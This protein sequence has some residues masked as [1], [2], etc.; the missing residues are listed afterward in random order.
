MKFLTGDKTKM[1]TRIGLLLAAAF[2][3][4]LAVPVA[5]AQSM[6][7]SLNGSVQDAQGAVVVGAGVTVKNAA[8]GETRT[9]TTNKEGYFSIPSLPAGAYQLTVIAKG[10]E[11]FHETGIALT[12]GDDRSINVQLKVGAVTETVEAVGNITELTPSSSGEKAFTM[13]ASEVQDLSLVSRDATELVNI[14]PGAVMTPNGAV[15]S[16]AF[17]GQAMGMN[18]TTGPLANENV[19]GM[20]VDVTTDGGHTFDP[21]AAGNAV[22]VTAN[23]DM[24][25]EIKLQTSNFTA[26]NAKGPVVVNTVTKN[27]GSQFHGDVHFIARN[28]VLNAIDSYEKEQGQKSTPNEHYYYPGAT[29]GGP[30]I[31]PKLHI[32]RNRDKL[33]FFDGFEAYRQIQDGGD[34]AA[35]VPT[36]AML[37]GDFSAV[38]G[39]GNNP[40]GGSALTATPAQSNFACSITGTCS[41]AGATGSLWGAPWLAFDPTKSVSGTRLQG[42]QISAAGVLNSSCLD[43]NGVALMSA[44][45]PKPTTPNGAYDSHGFNYVQ[46][47]TEPENMTQELARVDWDY[48]DKTKLY[49]TFNRSHQNATFPMGYWVETAAENSVPV[50]SPIIGD[51]TTDFVM[52]NFMHVISPSMTT[53]SR[54]SYTYENYPGNPQDPAKLQRADIPNFTLKGIWDQKTAP[55]LVTWGSGF[56]N[57]G[58]VGHAYPLLCYKKIPSFGED[59]TKVIHTHTLKAGV[60]YEWVDNVQ[61]N[62]NTW[63]EFPYATWYPA[64]S[65]NQYADT[66]MGVGHDGYSENAIPPTPPNTKATMLS[67]Y[68]Q[69]DWKINR[70]ISIQYGMRFDH[71]GKP[72]STPY[73]VAVWD[74]NGILSSADVYNNDPSAIAQN[75]GISWH[76]ANKKIPWSGQ[77]STTLFYS[78]RI[79]GAFDVFGNGRTVLRGG[80][81]QYRDFAIWSFGSANST[82]EG[83][84]AWTCGI[85]DVNCPSWEDVDTHSQGPPVF[86]QPLPAGQLPTPTGSGVPLTISGV[87]DARDKK[88]PYTN[89]YSVSIDQR[90]PFKLQTE[91]SYVGSGTHDTQTSMDVN[92]IPLGSMP[93]QLPQSPYCVSAVTNGDWCAYHFRPYQNYESITD[94]ETYGKSRFDSLQVSVQRNTG[95]LTLLINYT[96]SKALGDGLLGGDSTSGYPDG[97]VSEYYGVLPIDRPQ[98]LSTAYVIHLPKT[99]GGNVLARGLVNGWQISG[100]T[101]IESGANLTSGTGGWNFDWSPQSNPA[102]TNG[103]DQYSS[104][105][106]L[107]TPDVT[108]MPLLTCN[109]KKGNAKGYYVN[110]SCFSVPPGNGVNGT[111]KMPYIPGPKYWKSDLTMVKNFKIGDHQNAQFRAAAFDFLNHALLSFAPGD[112]NLEANNLKY[113][114]ADGTEINLNPDFGKANWHEGH[115][116][117]E[118][119]VKY[120]F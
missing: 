49:V 6:F 88:N 111:T 83:S 108:L 76:S 28:H 56:P 91:V 66:L 104:Q 48:S 79:G 69:D 45:L 11:R 107:G 15:N 64:V 57:L 113:N 78:P 89:T 33:F 21:G 3:L 20:G 60:Y 71:Y 59:L 25:S 52:V 101:Q 117:M 92:A 118:F 47:I 53:E 120:S 4:A 100:I 18:T 95:F 105:W 51:D 86:G 115:R 102:A 62:W 81:G 14:M 68:G 72:W 16:Q 109:P 40:A 10:F 27:G 42:C 58:D 54:F 96:Y 26:D 77:K 65:G 19:N 93:M 90:L 94:T 85:N 98:V 30:I 35:F 39:Y 75:T 114:T 67:F 82:A 63:G 112:T 37:G 87:V 46:D 36:A 97:G 8:S 116:I 32:N 1:K 70:H 29:I 106:L 9:A 119:E 44:Y 55:E 2:V 84:V 110:W 31:I 24:I 38:S 22:P 43:P 17:T 5:R 61:N 23:Q 50:P 74:P 7:A 12:G 73:G 41:Q 13:S 80:F 103:T 34:A 99:Q